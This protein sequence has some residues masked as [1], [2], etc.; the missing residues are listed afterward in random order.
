MMTYDSNQVVTSST[1]L[2][3]AGDGYDRANVTGADGV[4]IDSFW[5]YQIEEWN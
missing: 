5:D 2:T 3:N 1:S 4:N